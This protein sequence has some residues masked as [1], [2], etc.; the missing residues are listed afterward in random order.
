[1][2]NP[3]KFI[4]YNSNLH[5]NK[6][7]EK[8]CVKKGKKKKLFKNYNLLFFLFTMLRKIAMSWLCSWIFDI[9]DATNEKKHKSKPTKVIDTKK[10]SII[11]IVWLIA[12]TSSLCS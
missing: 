5:E 4:W 8:K 10:K 9:I 7:K 6:K 11:A 1:M 3:V 2:S 12:P